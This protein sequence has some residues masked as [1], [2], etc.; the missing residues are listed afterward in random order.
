[1]M[2]LYRKQLLY[3]RSKYTTTRTTL[4]DFRLLFL[5]V[6]LNLFGLNLSYSVGDD[7]LFSLTYSWL[8]VIKLQ[9][10]F[11]T[12]LKEMLLSVSKFDDERFV[13]G[14]KE[15]IKKR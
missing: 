13:L 11:D 10:T 3:L 4:F 14:T 5:F 7:N 1:M 2:L 12:K 8:S 6:S 15:C 9:N